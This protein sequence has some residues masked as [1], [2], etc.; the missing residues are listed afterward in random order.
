MVISSLFADNELVPIYRYYS[1][2]DRDHYYA[3][4]T[5]VAKKW[6]R[7]GIEFYAFPDQV[8]GTVP[9]NRYYSK[10][11]KDHFYAKKTDVASKW[12]RQGVEFYAFPDPVEG[13]IPIYRFYDKKNKDHFYTKDPNPKGNWTPQGIEFYAYEGPGPGQP[14]VV[15]EGTTGSEVTERTVPKSPFEGYYT[16][17]GSDSAGIIRHCGSYEEYDGFRWEHCIINT[18]VVIKIE[19][20]NSSYT[21]TLLAINGRDLPV[22]FDGD[23]DIGSWIY[24]SQVLDFNIQL[25]EQYL[26]N[27]LDKSERLL[28]LLRIKEGLEKAGF[29]FRSVPLTK[30]GNVNFSFTFSLDKDRKKPLKGKGDITFN[31]VSEPQGFDMNLIAPKKFFVGG[32]SKNETRWVRND[33]AGK[34]VFDVASYI[35]QNNYKLKEEF[36]RLGLKNKTKL[37]LPLL[38]HVVDFDLLEIEGLKLGESPLNKVWGSKYP[39]DGESMRLES[40]DHILTVDKFLSPYRDLLFRREVTAFVR[41][42]QFHELKGKVFNKET[43]I[44]ISGSGDEK[45]FLFLDMPHPKTGLPPASFRDYIEPEIIEKQFSGISNWKPLQYLKDDN[46]LV[47]LSSTKP[48]SFVIFNLDK[49]TVEKREINLPLDSRGRRVKFEKSKFSVIFSSTFPGN[50]ITKFVEGGQQK[51]ELKRIKTGETID[52]IYVSGKTP[53]GAPGRRTKG[54]TKVPSGSGIYYPKIDSTVVRYVDW[55]RIST[56]SKGLAHIMFD[57]FIW[58]DSEN[59]WYRLFSDNFYTDSTD[60]TITFGYVAPEGFQKVYSI[61]KSE[62]SKEFFDFFSHFYRVDFK[63]S[64]NGLIRTTDDYGSIYVFNLNSGGIRERKYG[65]LQIKNDMLSDEDKEYLKQFEF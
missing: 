14:S 54:R 35:T 53:V 1:Q 26:P 6:T 7:E 33:E 63:I 29:P 20:V 3:K 50:Y 25:W 13:S 15:S 62:Q 55:G 48:E 36:F 42:P 34:L 49:G 61:T 43:R 38:S 41:K 10:K 11:D 8:E 28:T 16:F 44:V 19:E 51:I 65:S 23:F 18:Q 57:N 58:T 60:R 40:E 52:S 9:I 4:K 39:Y 31:S 46:S 22:D 21:L 64:D 2:K 45:E 17:F 24:N 37:K 27:T 12:T 59:I 56:G 47:F 30:S 32:R 5:D